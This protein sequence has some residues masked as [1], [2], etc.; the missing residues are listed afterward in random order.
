LVISTA[1]GVIVTRVATDQDVGEQ[2]VGQLFNNPRVMLLSAGVLGL[3]GLV[4]GMPNLVFLLFTAALLGLAW[5]L[6]GREQQAPRAVEEPVVPDNPQ[7]AEA[8]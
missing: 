6:R 7:A 4:P 1:A 2:M 5:W 3:L 8:S